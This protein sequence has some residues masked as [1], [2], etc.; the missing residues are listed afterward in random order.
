MSSKNHYFRK[1]SPETNRSRAVFIGLLFPVSSGC[2]KGFKLMVGGAPI[3][4]DFAKQVGADG[5]TTDAASAAVLAKK[6]AG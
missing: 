1:S 5:Y 4:E 3:T 2:L 6:L